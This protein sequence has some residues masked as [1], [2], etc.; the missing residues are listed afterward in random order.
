MLSNQ[1]QSYPSRDSSGLTVSSTG[2][3]HRRPTNGTH[4]RGAVPVLLDDAGS[5]RHQPRAT[6]TSYSACTDLAQRMPPGMP[7][8]MT[9]TCPVIDSARQN[10]TTCAAMSS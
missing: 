6:A 10:M 9:S 3:E 5:Y 2:Q 8:S 1:S 4:E 7:P